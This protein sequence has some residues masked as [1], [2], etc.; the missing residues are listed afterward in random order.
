M[1][2]WGILEQQICSIADAFLVDSYAYAGM[3]GTLL[4][5]SRIQVY[6]IIARSADTWY[7]NFKG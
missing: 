1:Y 2:S 6:I 4:V 5:D 3:I 7:G